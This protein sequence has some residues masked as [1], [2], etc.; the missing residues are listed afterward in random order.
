MAI[1][2]GRDRMPMLGAANAQSAGP[3]GFEDGR[4]HN[5]QKAIEVTCDMQP[6]RWLHDRRVE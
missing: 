1:L 3:Q 6:M 4:E 5:G 2:F